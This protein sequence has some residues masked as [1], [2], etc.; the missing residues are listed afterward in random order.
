MFFQRL[1]YS[2]QL[3]KSSRRYVKIKKKLVFFAFRIS[4]GNYFN[5]SKGQQPKDS[6]VNILFTSSF[7]SNNSSHITKEL[8]FN[9][10]SKVI[11]SFIRAEIVR[12]ILYNEKYS[13]HLS[14][15][16]YNNMT[17][18][19]AED[20]PGSPEQLNYNIINTTVKFYKHGHS[21]NIHLSFEKSIPKST[22]AKY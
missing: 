2:I 13:C 9:G 5:Q 11:N 17:D 8:S 7:L 14:D 4:G 22:Y 6:A 15:V 19:T 12:R 16:L 20:F 18:D 1:E 21:I 3:R 10:I